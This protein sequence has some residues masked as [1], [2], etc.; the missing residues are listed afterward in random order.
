MNQ[1][2]PMCIFRQ[3]SIL[4][5]SLIIHI[6]LTYVCNRL[7]EKEGYIARAAHLLSLIKNTQK[8]SH[9]I[10]QPHNQ[11]KKLNKTALWPSIVVTGQI[12]ENQKDSKF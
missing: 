6:L 1:S 7:A 5:S 9:K 10:L 11:R 12:Y 4:Y 8:R 2:N 3:N